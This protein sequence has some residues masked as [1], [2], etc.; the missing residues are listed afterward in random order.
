MAIINTLHIYPVKSCA[1]ITLT[2]AT[3][4]RAGLESNRV[5]DREWMVVD[6]ASGLFLT[7]RQSPRMALIT[8]SL[9]DGVLKLNAPGQAELLVPLTGFELRHPEISVKVWNHECRAFDAGAQAAQWFSAFLGRDLRLV[10]FDA[11]HRRE[12]SMEWT[13]GVSALNR[14]SDGYPILLI[15]Q[16]SLDDLNDRLQEQG[17]EALPMNRFRPNIVLGRIGPYE[18]D[19]VVTLTSADEK[20]SLKPV[21]PCPRCPIPSIEQSTGE[22]GPDPLDI[23][24]QYRS[25]SRTGGVVFGQ[26]L[27]TLAGYG[28]VLCVGQELAE[29]WNF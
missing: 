8:P 26:N 11:A 19:H 21:K 6:A 27:I 20:I 17:R 22:F 2:E 18:E 1:G 29:E 9:G 14:F 16:G 13:G 23:L 4:G 24:S 3:L 5:G 10:R 7:Q 12:A 28:E 25:E 15:S